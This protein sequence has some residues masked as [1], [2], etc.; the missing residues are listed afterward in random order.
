MI[1]GEMFMFHLTSTLAPDE[2][3]REVW[4]PALPVST[5]YAFIEAARRHG[6][7]ALCGVCATVTVNGAIVSARL[8]YS[9]VA[10]K[11]V[12]APQAE[13]V[14]VGQPPTEDAFRSAAALARE[15]V[16]VADDYVA[17]REYRQHIVERLTI[18]ALREAAE[19]A[20]NP[21]ETR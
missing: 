20:V 4:F 15:V 12:R 2:V 9:G 6:D 19:R 5:G 21:E 18:R 10:T 14:L 11:P 16:N 7:Y 17:S 3:L 1:G 8:A 13:Q